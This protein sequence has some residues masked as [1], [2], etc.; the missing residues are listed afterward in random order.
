MRQ[1]GQYIIGEILDIIDK[2]HE[3]TPACIVHIKWVPGHKNIEGNEKADQA[4]KTAATPNC[5]SPNM[6][7]KSAQNR[8]IQSMTKTK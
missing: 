5:I 1:T 6:T 8:S 3:R 4:A 7:M 2:I